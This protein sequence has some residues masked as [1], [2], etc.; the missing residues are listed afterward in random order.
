MPS[1]ALPLVASFLAQLSLLSGGA[2]DVVV[3][4]ADDVGYEDVL[5]VPTPNLDRLAAIG[6][7]YTH[8]F[9]NPTCSPTRRS[10]MF[11]RFW[12]RGNG[13]ACNPP[14]DA[15]PDPAE[16]SLAE[17]APGSSALF[18]KWHLG[19]NPFG[20]VY[21]LA[22]QAHGWDVWRAGHP[23]NV[24]DAQCGGSANYTSWVRVDDGHSRP[25][26]EYEPFVVRD[27]FLSWW[28]RTRSPRLVWLA[29]QLAHAPYHVPPAELLPPGWSVPP[30][31]RGKYET[32]IVAL[33]T[34][35]GTVMDEL[36]FTTDTLVFV[37]DN[38]T[39]QQVAPPG[40]WAKGTTY[41]RGI[42][43]PLVVAGPGYDSG[44]SSSK[45][46]HV[47]D[48]YATVA[49]ALGADVSPGLDAIPLRSSGAHRWIISGYGQDRCAR[50]S[51]Y[52]LRR[53]PAGDE[54]FDLEHDPGEHV[55]VSGAPQ[56][57]LAEE[58][59]RAALDEYESR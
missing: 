24:S 2:G 25:T 34:L 14:A 54:L 44:M 26:N 12:T 45:L 40:V 50:T 39:P 55:N 20:P 42:H 57:A 52:K 37:G 5:S 1:A 9:A 31:S 27:E 35:L 23:M 16:I 41:E 58:E 28:T 22:A 4:V 8:A 15:A 10:L 17:L 11:G 32:M 3:F 53:T 19:P 33:D 30:G 51:R 38:G 18:G 29:P 59:L 36:D 48:V 6:T 47:V 7:T 43:V 21:E 49:L 56:H 13:V 46:V